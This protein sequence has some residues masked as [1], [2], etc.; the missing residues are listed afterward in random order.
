MD[1]DFKNHES[2]MNSK[3]Y[4]GEYSLR[5]W[6]NLIFLKKSETSHV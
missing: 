3:I 1:I 4:Y 2:V 6:I 5:H